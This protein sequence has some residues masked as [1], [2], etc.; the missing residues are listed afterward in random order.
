M[1]CA[2]PDTMAIP[3]ETHLFSH[4]LAPL[5]DRFQHGSAASPKTAK[6]FL[7][8]DAMRDMLR[9]VAD[10][11]LGGVASA[12]DP[13]AK[14]IVERTPWHAYHLGLIGD[15]YPDAA[16]IHIVRDG[17]DVARSLVSQE[18]GPTTMAEAAEEWRSAVE[19]A[20]AAGTRLERYR[21]VRYEALL[22]DPR[23]QI[24]GLYRWLGLDDR[25][26]VVEL[27]L[28]EAGVR[29]N[30]DSRSPLV[31]SGKWR[32]EL[33]ARDVRTFERVGGELLAQLGYDRDPPP[34]RRHAF[35][36]S[37][38]SWASNARRRGGSS[39]RAQIVPS[40][41]GMPRLDRPYEPRVTPIARMEQIQELLDQ[42]VG[43]FLAGD[44][45]TV[46]SLLDP[47]AFVRRTAGDLDERGR[48][49]AAH[50]RFR[51]AVAEAGSR[52]V[53]HAGSEIHAG[54]LT[55]VVVL[56]YV[57]ATGEAS[58][59]TLVLGIAGAVID[60][61]VWYQVGSARLPSGVI[62]APG[63]HGASARRQG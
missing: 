60:R 30:T 24:G 31:T 50:Q 33:S 49:V 29:F 37:A 12:L 41:A 5:A 62:D 61:V 6:V 4:G 26:D 36:D 54:E 20:Q 42:F 10:R 52:Q 23:K 56:R 2:H 25:A 8:Q 47:D 43:S 40:S 21:E 1:I 28:L 55:S 59:D 39:G 16:V 38:R 9:E 58:A 3:S 53:A 57:D 19:A 51:L 11:V 35:G 18:W 27:A 13:G 45:A 48:D 34:P 63:D 44:A 7:P 32:A 17:R 46:V 22:A 14:L 15:L